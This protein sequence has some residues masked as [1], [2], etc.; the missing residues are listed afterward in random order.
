MSGPSPT[1][2]R[3]SSEVSLVAASRDLAGHPR[4]LHLQRNA[5]E[6]VLNGVRDQR[7]AVGT[8]LRLPKITERAAVGVTQEGAP[9][10]EAFCSRAQQEA[11]LDL[12]VAAPEL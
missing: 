12:G 2:P 10:G 8:V 4:D 6:L 3:A 9:H 11:L 5:G 7:R 1:I